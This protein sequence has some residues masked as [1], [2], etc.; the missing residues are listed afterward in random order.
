[1]GVQHI[2]CVH[3]GCSGD[4]CFLMMTG[5]MCGLLSTLYILSFIDEIIKKK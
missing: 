1:M 4:C 5:D 2:V 3:K